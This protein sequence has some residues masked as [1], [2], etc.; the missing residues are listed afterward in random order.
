MSLDI[1][2]IH[3]DAIV[4]YIYDKLDEEQLYYPFIDLEL[5]KRIR[6]LCEDIYEAAYK[7]GQETTKLE[8]KVKRP[9]IKVVKDSVDEKILKHFYGDNIEFE[10]VKP[11]KKCL[12]SNDL[13][14]KYLREYSLK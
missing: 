7:D 11:I 8:D 1:S 13:Y 3:N 10:Y 14:E 9:I 4:E 12:N 2:K 5:E 6:H